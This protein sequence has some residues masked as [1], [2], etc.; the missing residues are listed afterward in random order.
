MLTA[1]RELNLEK[2]T[3]VLYTTDH[4]EMLGEHGLWQKFMFYEPSVGV[5]LIVRAPGVTG[6]GGRSQTPVSQ[7]QVLPTLLELCGLPVPA[8]L[9]AASMAADLREPSRTRDN[10]VYAEYNLRNPRA[11]YMIRSGDFKFN[12]YLSDTPELYNLREDPHEMKN[13]A[14]LPAHRAKAEELKARIFAWNPG[15]KQGQ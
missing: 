14:A 15:A 4:G 11:K 13:L 2:D 5:P 3:I 10:T 12:W 1:L 9:D 7:V 8:G 6:A